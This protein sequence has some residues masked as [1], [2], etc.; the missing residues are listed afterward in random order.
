MIFYSTR[1]AEAGHDLIQE[2]LLISV[3]AHMGPP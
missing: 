1:E 2:A 3:A